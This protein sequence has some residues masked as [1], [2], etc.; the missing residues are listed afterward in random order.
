MTESLDPTDWS[1]LGELQRD[2]RLLRVAATSMGHL[3]GVVDELARFGG[4]TTDV[5]HSRPPCRGPRGP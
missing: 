2:G 3:E 5:V 1:I 4:T